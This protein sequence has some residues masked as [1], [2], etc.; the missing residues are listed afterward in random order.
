MSLFGEVLYCGHRQLKWPDLVS[1]CHRPPPTPEAKGLGMRQPSCSVAFGVGL[2]RAWPIVLGNWKSDSP[3]WPKLPLPL[4][5]STMGSPPRSCLSSKPG[6]PPS[7][8]PHSAIQ[9]LTQAGGGGV[10]CPG[11]APGELHPPALQ[12]CSHLPAPQVQK[13]SATLLCLQ[14]C[15]QRVPAQNISSPFLWLIHACHSGPSS[16]GPNPSQV[17]KDKCL[18]HVHFPIP[19]SSPLPHDLT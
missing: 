9:T 11:P 19:G 15:P 13:A 8:L 2:E 7:S 18:P 16:P 5:N 6:L 3:S 14:L 10:S 4:P 17:P 12:A 1:T